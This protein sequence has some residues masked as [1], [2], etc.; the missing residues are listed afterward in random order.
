MPPTVPSVATVAQLNPAS[1]WQLAEHPSPLLWLPSSQLSPI[2]MLPFPQLAAQAW[3]LPAELRQIG[4]LVQVFEQ[5]VPSPL[6]RPL[7]PP[8]PLG[9]LVALVP[10][11]QASP[12]SFTPFPQTA[13]VH[14]PGPVPE[15]VAPGSIWQLL[16][17]P[18]PLTVLPSSQASLPLRTLSPQIG[19][20]GLPGTGQRQ[21]A[22][23]AEQLAAQPSP[24]PVLLSSQASVGA[25]RPSP[26]M[27]V[28]K[29]ALPMF[30]QT[31]LF[32]IWQSGVQPSPAVMLWSSHCS[33]GSSM[34]FP[35]VVVMVDG[36]STEPPSTT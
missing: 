17:Q 33:P 21:P 18:S 29:H 5:P 26:Q 34:P 16:E 3:V 19:T 23:T 27:A 7:G 6:K 9:K 28:S 11:S 36:M 31:Q 20:Q 10:Q 8:Q 22:S 4:S 14:D 35:Q 12:A 13:L 25:S 15:Q 24:D 32:S 1:I 2:S 30:G